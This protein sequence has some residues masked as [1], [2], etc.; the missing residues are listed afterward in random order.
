MNQAIVQFSEY[1]QFTRKFSLLTVKSYQQ[2]LTIFFRFLHD[3]DWRFDALSLSQARTFLASQVGLGLT[4]TTLKRR[5]ATL[6][7]FYQY[8]IDLDHMKVNPF[9]LLRTPKVKKRLPTLVDEHLVQNLLQQPFDQASVLMM[10]DLALVELLYGSG[11]RASEVVNLTIQDLNLAQRMLRILGKGNKQRMVPI[12]KAC[13]QSL[14]LYFKDVRPGL[15]KDVEASMLSN[16]VFLNHHGQPL[17]VRGLQYILKQ[18]S[19]KVGLQGNLHPHQLRHTFASQL[20]DNGAD[21]RT[22]QELLGHATINT[23]QIYTH[24]SKEALQKEYR[25]AHPR[26]LKKKQ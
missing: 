2:D 4:P 20:L 8:L 17:T 14:S 16:R 24:V 6:K 10:R 18:M 9:Q 13:Q 5:M 11:L 7:H 23:T 21:L 12:T 22:I 26:A 3:H 15:I 1:L 25:S 19:R